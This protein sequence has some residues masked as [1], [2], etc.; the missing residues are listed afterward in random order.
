MRN[1]N[2]IHQHG[3]NNGHDNLRKFVD[4]NSQET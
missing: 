1:L 3:K 4:C 2:M